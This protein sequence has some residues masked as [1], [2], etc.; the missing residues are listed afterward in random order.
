MRKG[1]GLLWEVRIFILLRSLGID[2]QSEK[3]YLRK[4]SNSSKSSKASR[5]SKASKADTTPNKKQVQDF[6][7]DS[8]HIV[9]KTNLSVTNSNIG[10]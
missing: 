8:S 4:N 7:E 3:S 10:R 1:V 5:T 2:L 6:T 9:D